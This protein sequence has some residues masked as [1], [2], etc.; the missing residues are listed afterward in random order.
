MQSATTGPYHQSAHL[1]LLY[2]SS[3][4]TLWVAHLVFTF[5]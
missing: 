2:L 3:L 1:T 4:E 5:H